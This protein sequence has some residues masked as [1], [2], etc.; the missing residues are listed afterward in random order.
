MRYSFTVLLL[1]VLIAS[2]CERDEISFIPDNNSFC[3]IHF[4]YWPEKATGLGSCSGAP[5]SASLEASFTS[6]DRPGIIIAQNLYQASQPFIAAHQQEND[7]KY[8]AQNLSAPLSNHT[9]SFEK[10]DMAP[11]TRISLYLGQTRYIPE[12][13][14]YWMGDFPAGITPGPSRQ[15]KWQVFVQRETDGAYTL[16]YV[17]NGVEVLEHRNIPDFGAAAFSISPDALGRALIYGSL[18][19]PGEELATWY[20]QTEALNLPPAPA[21]LFTA[22][23]FNIPEPLQSECETRSLRIRLTS[24]TYTNN[25]PQ[26]N[27]FDYFECNTIID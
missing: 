16:G 6:D 25:N 20:I 4:L 3:P 11:G 13:N 18:T 27:L 7:N 14:Q 26:D 15:H 1:M 12:S 8:L 19:R 22:F 2:A 23:G 5:S 24:Y 9:L 17:A 21:N 10:I